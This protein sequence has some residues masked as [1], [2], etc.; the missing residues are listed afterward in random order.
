MATSSTPLLGSARKPNGTLGLLVAGGILFVIGF[1]GS[2]V[3]LGSECGT[4]GSPV[5]LHGRA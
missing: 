5:A 4:F 2:S 3:L 1:A